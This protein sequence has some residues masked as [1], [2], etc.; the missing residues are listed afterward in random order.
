MKIMTETNDGFKIA[1][2][3]LEI[4]GPGEMEGTRQSGA[5]LFKLANIVSDKNILEAARD[6]VAN[7]LENDYELNAP[8]NQVIRNYLQLK[9]TKTQWSK[10][11]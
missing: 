2:K 6:S 9:K 4:R 3:D 11:S 5:L 7:I 8:E 10:I 1:E